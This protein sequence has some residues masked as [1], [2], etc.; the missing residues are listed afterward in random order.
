MVL[1]E[2]RTLI[3]SDIYILGLEN[4]GACCGCFGNSNNQSKFAQLVQKNAMLSS[5]L[6]N[7]LEKQASEGFIRNTFER[8]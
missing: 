8:H 1:N 5:T 2:I 6:Y 3:I 7:K 4:L